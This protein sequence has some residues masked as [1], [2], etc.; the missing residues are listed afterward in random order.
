MREKKSSCTVFMEKPE[1]K[2]TLG[3]RNRKGEDTIKMCLTETGQVSDSCERDQEYSVALKR[4]FPCY[5]K[6][7]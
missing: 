7:C 5:L 2:R 1:G 6:N 3:R 4:G